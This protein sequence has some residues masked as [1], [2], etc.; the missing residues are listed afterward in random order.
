[1][2]NLEKYSRSQV[3]FAIGYGDPKSDPYDRILVLMRLTP[4]TPY[5]NI[6]AHL[7]LLY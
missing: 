1:M 5:L 4:N 7:G 3:L 2:M 6:A